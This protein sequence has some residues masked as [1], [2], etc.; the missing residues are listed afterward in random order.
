[1]SQLKPI[2][3]PNSDC[4]DCEAGMCSHDLCAGDQYHYDLPAAAEHYFRE[5]EEEKL[6]EKTVQRMIHRLKLKKKVLT[7]F[8][9]YC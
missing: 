9:S 1:M 2:E 4:Y 5:Q 8:P 7:K 6:L 3:D